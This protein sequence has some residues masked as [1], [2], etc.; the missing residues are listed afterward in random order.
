MEEKTRRPIRPERYLSLKI[1]NKKTKT[2]NKKTK[3]KQTNKQTKH[4]KKINKK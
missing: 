4:K 1:K 3:T 2:K